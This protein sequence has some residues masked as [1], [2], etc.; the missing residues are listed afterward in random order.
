[1]SHFQA[2]SP[3]LA[4][5][6]DLSLDATGSFVL[7]AT[8]EYFAPKENLVFSADYDGR[9]LTWPLEGDYV[10]STAYDTPQLLMD[11]AG[12]GPMVCDV[13]GDGENDVVATVSDD[14]G[15]AALAT[16]GPGSF[17]DRSAAES[18]GVATASL[19]HPEARPA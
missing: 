10:N 11:A 2:A 8:D 18:D 13:D 1:L 7:Y 9:I 6:T 17:S 16:C 3:S 4:H 14:R 12:V 15:R 19:I 5:T